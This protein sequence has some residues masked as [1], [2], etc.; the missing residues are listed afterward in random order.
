MSKTRGEKIAIISRDK[1]TH[2]HKRIKVESSFIRSATFLA[3]DN[4]M[5]LAYANSGEEGEGGGG[6]DGGGGGRRGG[7]GG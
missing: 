5:G 1:A 4:I 7:G 3:R 2:L 6:D